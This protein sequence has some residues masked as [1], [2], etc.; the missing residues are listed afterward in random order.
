MS[1]NPLR[2]LTGYRE[3][4]LKFIETERGSIAPFSRPI[5]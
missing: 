2:G 5:P 4:R 3:K 1:G